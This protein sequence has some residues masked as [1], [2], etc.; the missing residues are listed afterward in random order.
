[1]VSGGPML[2][3]RF[4]GKK[5]DL[6]AVFE[7][8]GRVRSGSMTDEE[9]CELEDKACP[10]CGSC[11]G[12]FTA[13]S[14]NCLTEALGL[15]LPGNGTIPAVTAARVRLAKS[16]GMKVMEL[17]EKNIRP[18][19]IATRNAF[20]NAIAVDMALGCSTNTVLHVP[21]IAHEAE[22]DV[23]LDMFH[24]ISARTPHICSLSPGGPNDLDDL[25][26]AGGI[27]AVLKQLA[28]E[29]SSGDGRTHGFGKTAS[30]KPCICQGPG[31]GNHSPHE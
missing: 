14:M 17:V 23:N 27:Q 26:S 1:M 2:S 20:N 28:D 8:V 5:T 4:Q 19:D 21:A 29:G 13:N 18:R 3:G 22:I 6:V 25:N 16:A 9:L 31:F 10:G 15:G 30:G 12:M 24:E 7:G 11:A